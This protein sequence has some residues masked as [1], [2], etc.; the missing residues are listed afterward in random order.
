MHTPH[1]P[2]PHTPPPKQPAGVPAVPI[3]NTVSTAS[4]PT[5]QSPPEPPLQAAGP[6]K[7]LGSSLVSL[8]AAPS[9]ADDA[10]TVIKPMKPSNV[11]AIHVAPGDQLGHFELIESVGTG[12]MATVLKARDLELGR[13]VA[14]KIL[15][16][17]TAR[18]SEVVTRFKQ[19]ARA[20]AKLDHDHIARVYFCG[21]DQGLHFIAFEFVEG[22]TLRHMIDRQGTIPPR[23]CVRYMIQVASGLAHAHERGVVHRDIKPSNILIT[24]EGRAKIV[25]MGLARHL[26]S[27]SINGG[28]TQSGV[29]LGTF[30]YISPEQALDPRRADVRSD[31]YSLGCSIYHA[32][33][34]RPPV[35]EGTAAKKLHAHQ[36][37]YPLDPRELNPRVPDALAVVL[38]RMMAKDPARRYQTPQELIRDLSVLAREW[39]MNVDGAISDISTLGS[40]SHHRLVPEPPHLPTS[41]LIIGSIIVTAIAVFLIATSTPGPA[42]LPLAETAGPVAD[43]P[44]PQPDLST[45]AP[46]TTPPVV[47]VRSMRPLADAASLIT[48]FRAGDTRIQLQRGQTYD[49]TTLVEPLIFNGERLRIESIVDPEQTGLDSTQFPVVRIPALGARAGNLPAGGLVFQN[50]QDLAIQGVTFLISS[51]DMFD[52]DQPQS[53]GLGIWNTDRVEIQSCRFQVDPASPIPPVDVTGVMLGTPT[54]TRNTQFQGAHLLFDL[55]MNNSAIQIQ[56]RVSGSIRH[57]A[58]GP[59]TAAIAVLPE[60]TMGISPSSTSHR[61]ALNECTFMLDSGSCV[62]EAH[63][64]A[65]LSV[66][67]GY[68]IFANASPPPMILMPGANPAEPK[69]TVLRALKDDFAP[70][71]VTFAGRTGESNAYYRVVPYANRM[72][73]YTFEECLAMKPSPA[74]DTSAIMLTERSPWELT[75]PRSR[76]ASDPEQAEQ[77]FRLNL[78]DRKL[79]I[80]AEPR[81]LGAKYVRGV[82][83]RIYPDRAWPPPKPKPP[84]VASTGQRVYWPEAEATDARDRIYNDFLAAYSKL[85]PGETLLIAVNG[86]VPVPSLPDRET[87]RFTLKAYPGFTPELASS[88][89][90]RL[91]D[92]SLFKLTDGQLTFENLGLTLNGRQSIVALSGG[93]SVT[94]RNCTISL[95]ER[96]EPQAVVVIADPSREMRMDPADLPPSPQIRFE[97]TL[98]RGKGRALW[99]QYPRPLDL[100]AENTAF[101]LDGPL[102]EIDPLGKDIASPAPPVSVHLAQVTAILNGPVID[103]SAPIEGMNRWITVEVETDLCL[104]AP[105]IASRP[106][107]IVMVQDADPA[108][109]PKAYISWFAIGP[110]VYGNFD[111]LTTAVELRPSIDQEIGRAHV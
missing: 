33:T 65:A 95:D 99:L 82:Q 41:W 106:R 27:H 32:L 31:L 10:P 77:A 26:E 94:F 16:P 73:S 93:R 90:T 36:Y 78:D 12:G 91:R 45:P 88:G 17:E 15:P 14:L 49:L 48:A 81:V 42:S 5:G 71:T 23:D 11:M 30:D 2:D 110:S 3:R 108:A 57:G 69:A 92:A 35:P 51:P 97:N 107:P 29:T 34:G 105:M 54:G 67:A 59:H 62:L 83:S 87:L 58:F 72:R 86:V 89:P 79:H 100:T 40:N 111:R 75:N 44:R 84:V 74:V 96:E 19:E 103:Y 38:S 60:S 104:F 18:D 9:G 25:D 56:G 39:D 70:I 47:P 61:L 22:E 46:G 24:P 28:V 68:C 55:G 13:I 7:L 80:D 102:V 53:P 6:V 20:A 109:E 76:L 64:N 21:E 52:A 101:V 37:D 43:T 85:E 1:N 66:E 8:Q 50:M 4:H 63:P 98:V